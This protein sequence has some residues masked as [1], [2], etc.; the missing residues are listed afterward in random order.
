MGGTIEGLVADGVRTE[1]DL[2]IPDLNTLEPEGIISSSVEQFFV[3]HHTR[4]FAKT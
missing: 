1:Q 4:D 3:N 2:L